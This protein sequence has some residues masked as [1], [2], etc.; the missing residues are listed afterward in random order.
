MSAD[1]RIPAALVGAVAAT[2]LGVSA[3][4]AQPSAVP[5][6]L[7][8]AC[9]SAVE[10]DPEPAPGPAQQVVLDR[11]ALPSS[12]R[13][14]KVRRASGRLPYSTKSGLLVRHG[15]TPVDLVVP[16]AWR[17]RFA[18][19]RGFSV[20]YSVRILGCATTPP[21]WWSYAGGYSVR[22]PACVPL[23]VRVGGM[24]TTVRLAL[25]RPCPSSA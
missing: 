8:L 5:P 1:A 20:V 11:I 16:T 23:I 9:D 13:V 25:G 21:D 3:A 22:R 15:T 2:V 12:S 7:T 10:V 17:K 24:T 18:I 6:K 14:L 19:G 4:L